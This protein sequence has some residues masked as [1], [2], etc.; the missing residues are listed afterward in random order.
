MKIQRELPEMSHEAM[1]VKQEIKDMTARI[2]HSL[3]RLRQEV[4]LL[5][6]WSELLNLQ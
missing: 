6:R 3:A 2:W 4:V 5:R 1:K